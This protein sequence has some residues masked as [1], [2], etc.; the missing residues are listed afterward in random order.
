MD[1]YRNYTWNPST[2]P[3][4]ER[5]INDLRA[6]GIHLVTIIDPGTKIDVKHPI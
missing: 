2:F 6:Q 3:D 1:G 4:P 5:M